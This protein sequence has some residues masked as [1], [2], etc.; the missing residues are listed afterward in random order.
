MILSST[1]QGIRKAESKCPYDFLLE[2]NLTL[3]LKTNTGNMV[4]PPEVGQPSS[5]TCYLYFKD[6][7]DSNEI[8]EISFKEMVYKNIDKML[9]IYT[10]HYGYIKKKRNIFIKF[11]KRI[12]HQI[13]NG[14]VII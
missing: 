5:N 10:T 3:S 2:G 12:T 6:L 9:N 13:L 7:C 1:E 14:N 4:C 11:L 8:N